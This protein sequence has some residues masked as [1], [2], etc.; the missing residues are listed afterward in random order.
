MQWDEQDTKVNNAYDHD[1]DWLEKEESEW[2]KSYGHID[3]IQHDQKPTK[4]ILKSNIWEDGEDE[5]DE[6]ED[7]IPGLA[8]FLEAE[9]L[10]GDNEVI[11]PGELLVNALTGYRSDGIPS[12]AISVVVVDGIEANDSKQLMH[13]VFHETYL[14]ALEIR[15]DVTTVVLESEAKG[16]PWLPDMRR[17]LML[18]RDMLLDDDT[19]P[20]FA[21]YLIRTDSLFPYMLVLQDAITV[22]EGISPE[23]GFPTVTV[24]APT[25]WN[26]V[27]PLEDLALEAKAEADQE[28]AE[29][30]ALA[31]EMS[32]DPEAAE[33]MREV[34]EELLDDGN[35]FN[36]VR[37]S[38]RPQGDGWA[39]DTSDAPRNDD[40]IVKHDQFDEEEPSDTDASEGDM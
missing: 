38:G 17:A 6:K 12:A 26:T 27:V 5:E 36:W 16:N 19:D 20:G 2:E 4:E 13:I 15:P 1:D 34:G 40:W 29:M 9:R 24:L 8:E 33:I 39:R 30:E 28:I 22:V 11:M 10:A 3:N 14:K 23:T 37:D 21:L 18:Y 35:G 31:N 7:E 25:E 32:A